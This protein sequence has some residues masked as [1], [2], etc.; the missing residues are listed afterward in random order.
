MGIWYLHVEPIKDRT[1]IDI[2]LYTS[3]PM[4]VFIFP[5]VVEG[6]ELLSYIVTKTFLKVYSGSGRVWLLLHPLDQ[7]ELQTST[8]S[9]GEEPYKG[10][11]C[12]KGLMRALMSS[13]QSGT[14]HI[15]GTW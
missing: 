7:S 10:L 4:Y 3:M 14:W 12:P 9:Q 1:I 2:Y 6:V 8:Q 13:P 5:V 11:D 15:G